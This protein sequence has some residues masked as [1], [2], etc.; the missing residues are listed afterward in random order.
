[1]LALGNPGV[2]ASF[3]SGAHGEFVQQALIDVL[4]IEAQVEVVGGDASPQAHGR[5]APGPGVSETGA[6][7]SAHGA[8]GDTSPRG[9]DT[10][11]D[12]ST[13]Q[14]EPPGWDDVPSDPQ[15]ETEGWDTATPTSTSTSTSARAGAIPVEPAAAASDAR[16]EPS[17]D[18]ALT[19]HPADHPADPPA[20]HPAG[21]SADRRT[22]AQPEPPRRVAPAMDEPSADDVDAEDSGLVG[23][24]VVEQL[25][26]GRV[27]DETDV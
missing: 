8:G 27:I 26:G 9:P 13:Q 20:D 16:P 22:A 18:A 2:L 23:R 3:R 17:S 21:R 25:L 1:V 12:R 10:A 6:G 15:Q 24:A 4:G 19:G 14:P 7:S 11:A 5:A